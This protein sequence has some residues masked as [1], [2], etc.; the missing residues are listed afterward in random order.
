MLTVTEPALGETH[1]FELAVGPHTPK[2]IVPVGAPLLPLPIR[3]AVSVAV[4][5]E[6]MLRLFSAD[7]KV[8]LTVPLV[9]AAATP[10]VPAVTRATVESAAIT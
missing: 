10:A 6:E 9:L 4:L 7:R 2:V 5:P 1:G 3:V 8:G